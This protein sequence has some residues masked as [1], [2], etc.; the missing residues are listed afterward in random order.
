M[1]SLEELKALRSQAQVCAE[2][3]AIATEQ[4]PTAAGRWLRP[5]GRGFYLSQSMVVDGNPPSDVVRKVQQTPEAAELEALNLLFVAESQR[6]LAEK[7]LREYG[8]RHKALHQER[9]QAALWR[10][11]DA[12]GLF[13]LLVARAEA[14]AAQESEGSHG[15]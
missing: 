5:T 6:E 12:R 9:A 2:K 3:A 7:H 8:T 13:G 15:A 14:A 11:I 1:K 10:A 4:L